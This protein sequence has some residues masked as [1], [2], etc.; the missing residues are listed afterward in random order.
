MIVDVDPQAGFRQRQ[1][2]RN[3]DMAGAADNSH[4]GIF[5]GRWRVG[6]ADLR[7]YGHASFS[8]L[9]STKGRNGRMI[10]SPKRVASMKL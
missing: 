8:P 9:V 2:Q 1:H 4:L 3:A 10:A 6:S 7:P 5:D